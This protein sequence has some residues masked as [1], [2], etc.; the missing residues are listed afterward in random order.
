MGDIRT[1]ALIGPWRVVVQ[2]AGELLTADDLTD[3][4]ALDTISG[5]VEITITRDACIPTVS[6]LPVPFFAERDIAAHWSAFEG[7]DEVYLRLAR[8][9]AMAAGL[10][11]ADA[12]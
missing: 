10:N 1:E 9:E 7:A 8:A 6:G 4:A 3:S 12:R 2:D 5:D 11:A